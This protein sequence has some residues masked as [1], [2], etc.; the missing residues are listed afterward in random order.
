MY[1]KTW[2][3]IDLDAISE[4][5]KTIKAVCGKRLIAVLKADAYGCGDIQVAKTVIEAGASMIAVSSLDE[6]MMLR[7]QGYSGELLILGATDPSDIPVL[8]QN[9]IS[10][11]AY[12][13]KWVKGVTSKNCTGLKVHL[14]VETGMNRIGFKD[15][16]ELKKAK[17]LLMLRGC[18]LDGIFTH[19]AKAD[20]D[21]EM[22]MKQY[23]LFSQAV[24]AMD[25]PFRWIHCDNSDASLS[26][27]DPLSNACRIGIA[28]YGISSFNHDLKPALGLYTRI[29]MV[30]TLGPGEPIGYGSTYVTSGEEII[31]TAPIGYADGFI[32]A[33]QGRYVMVDGTPAEVVGRVCM[34]QV[35]LKLPEYKPENALVEI[36]GKTI[37]I[38]K[39]AEELNTIPYEI[40]CLISGRVTRVYIKNG[41]RAEEA[42]ERLSAK[43][44]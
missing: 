37:P 13:T 7:N 31:A 32:R 15:I 10:V 12:S 20:T 4:N 23:D 2:M 43:A 19:F 24:K 3:E 1:R 40:M 34:D 8:I 9:S 28:M 39:M 29:F 44:V 18:S 11:T 16:D 21:E 14:K 25:Y 6:A 36:F 42:N 35:M 30:K 5:I 33:N 26:F 22:T 27:R 41:I 17:G 38:E